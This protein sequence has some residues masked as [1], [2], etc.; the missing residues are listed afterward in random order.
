MVTW[1]LPLDRQTIPIWVIEGLWHLKQNHKP[2]PNRSRGIVEDTLQCFTDNQQHYVGAVVGIDAVEQSIF[3]SY[4]RTHKDAS[5]RDK[6]HLHCNN[7]KFYLLNTTSS[8]IK[9]DQIGLSIPISYTGYVNFL[10]IHKSNATYTVT[11]SAG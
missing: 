7:N 3:T 6:M 1:C 9:I 4:L 11:D 5:F 10:Q 8:T 2:L